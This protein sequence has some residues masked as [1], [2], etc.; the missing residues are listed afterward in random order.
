MEEVANLKDADVHRRV[1]LADALV[2]QCRSEG[3]ERRGADAVEELA[4]VEEPPVPR[5]G[6]RELLHALRFFI[7]VPTVEVAYLVYALSA[8]N[9]VLQFYFLASKTFF[10]SSWAFAQV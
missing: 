1:L 5:Q 3:D 8:F 6:R 9:D 4:E 2:E 10:Q 7:A